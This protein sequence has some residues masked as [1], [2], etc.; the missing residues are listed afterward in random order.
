MDEFI[1][2]EELASKLRIR[3][4][5]VRR[6]ARERLIPSIRITGKVTRYDYAE[7][8]AT[9]RSRSAREAE[10]EATRGYR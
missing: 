7:V 1:T 10:R 2:A 8:C 6:W 9:L 3:P 4:A 5:T